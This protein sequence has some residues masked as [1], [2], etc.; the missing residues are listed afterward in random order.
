[1]AAEPRDFRSTSKSRRELVGRNDYIGIC[2]DETGT[3]PVLHRPE[4]VV[5]FGAIG[6]AHTAQRCCPVLVVMFAVPTMVTVQP[7]F[8]A[9]IASMSPGATVNSVIVMTSEDYQGF[10]AVPA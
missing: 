3:T 8:T 4:Q 2:H 6:L 7:S 10:R 9:A 5:L 1:M